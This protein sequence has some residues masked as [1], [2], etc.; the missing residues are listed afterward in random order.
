VYLKGK[1]ST[2]KVEGDRILIGY[3]GGGV[4]VLSLVSL[5]SL[6]CEQGI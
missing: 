1:V 2:L 3:E 6:Y 5:A 4:E